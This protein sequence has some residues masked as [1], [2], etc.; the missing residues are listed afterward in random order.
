MSFGEAASAFP[1]CLYSATKV[2][3]YFRCFYNGFN[4][5]ATVWFPYQR[6][7]PIFELPTCFDSTTGRF[8]EELTDELIKPGIL[9]ANLFSGKDA[10]TYEFYN[11]SAAARQ[12]GMGQLPIQVYFAGRVK[13]RDGLTTGLDYSRVRDRI[14]DSNTTSLSSHSNFG[15]PNGNN[16]SSAIRHQ[17]TAT[18]WI[19]PTSTRMPRY[20]P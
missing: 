14:L 16:S 10:P 18:S 7:D 20:F 6:D 12:L 19:Q 15:G 5:D 17:H 2:T 1:G 4:E 13:F 3:E 8:D 9:P 11:P